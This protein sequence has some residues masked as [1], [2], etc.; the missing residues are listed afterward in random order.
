MQIKCW[1]ETPEAMNNLILLLIIQLAI[2][3]IPSFFCFKDKHEFSRCFYS[4][5]FLECFSSCKSA[6]RTHIRRSMRFATYFIIVLFASALNIVFRDTTT[7]PEIFNQ[8]V[9]STFKMVNR[10]SDLFFFSF[11]FI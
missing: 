5:L 11:L 3:F 7:D 8:S 2:I 9:L 4:F 10:Y 6:Y 1:P